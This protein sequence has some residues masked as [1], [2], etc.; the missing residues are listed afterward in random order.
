[1]RAILYRYNYNRCSLPFTG[2]VFRFSWRLSFWLYRKRCF[3]LCAAVLLSLPPGHRSAHPT[4]PSLAHIPLLP[5]SRAHPT[6]L[7]L[8]SNFSSPSPPPSNHF[9]AAVRGGA[10]LHTINSTTRLSLVPFPSRL[11]LFGRRRLHLGLEVF[12]RAP[13][14]ASPQQPRARHWLAT[15]S[16]VRTFWV[17]SFIRWMV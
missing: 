9:R 1:M 11:G 4:P 14:V 8:S 12:L 15:Y 3:N 7:S 17:R 16:Q 6:P 2:M 5:L 10:R 13:R